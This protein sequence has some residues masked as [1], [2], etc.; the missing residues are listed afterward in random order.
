MYCAEKS[1][2]PPSLL[3]K[4]ENQR[5]NWRKH[6]Y[7]TKHQNRKTLVLSA[8]PEKTGPETDQIRKTENPSAPP[9]ESFR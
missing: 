6:E 9:Y 7:R 8:K 3:S 2:K 5:L 4:T 1:Q